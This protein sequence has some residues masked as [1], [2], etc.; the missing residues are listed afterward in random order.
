VAATKAASIIVAIAVGWMSND[1]Y[2]ASGADDVETA[3]EA[4]VPAAPTQPVPVLAQAQPSEPELLSTQPAESPALV[5]APAPTTSLAADGTP[6]VVRGLVADEGGRPLSSAQVYV[7]DLD[8]GV[9]TQQDG[10]YDLT[11]PAEPDSFELTVARIGY[12]QQ[13]RAISGREGDYV[14]ADFRLREEALTLDE[15]VVSA[16]VEARVVGVDW[17]K[18]A[19]FGTPP[20]HAV[21][22]NAINRTQFR[23]K[24]MRCL[25]IGPP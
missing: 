13:A 17:A 1:L 14:A 15:I 16:A 24:K 2:R 20:L 23:E 22:I 11:L 21:S 3:A 4:P 8:V 19:R 18:A 6:L 7:A 9:L 10:T 25:I 12:R 5:A